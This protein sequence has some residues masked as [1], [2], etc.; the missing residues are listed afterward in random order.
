MRCKLLVDNDD[1]LR[2]LILE[3]LKDFD[4]KQ[5]TDLYNKIAEIALEKKLLESKSSYSF[6]GSIYLDKLDEARIQDIVWDLIIEGIL[7]P[8]LGDGNNN[9]LPFYHLTKKGRDT[10]L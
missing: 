8:G 3:A 10:I 4:K 6:G 5:V 9:N 7:R 1:E 2:E